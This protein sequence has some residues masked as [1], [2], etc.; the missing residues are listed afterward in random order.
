MNDRADPADS[1]R[2][3]SDV[4]A[5]PEK[6]LDR[7]F[8]IVF[9]SRRLKEK[10]IKDLKNPRPVLPVEE[11]SGNAIAKAIM[12]LL[13]R[14]FSMKEASDYTQILGDLAENAGYPPSSAEIY[15]SD[16]PSGRILKFTIHQDK[17]SDAGKERLLANQRG[18][19]LGGPDYLIDRAQRKKDNAARMVIGSDDVDG[20]GLSFLGSALKDKPVLAR[21]VLEN[22]LR[23]E[24]YIRIP[25]GQTPST[26][27]GQA[28]PD[29]GIALNNIYIKTQGRLTLPQTAPFDL[30]DFEGFTFK[31]ISLKEAKP[32][33]KQFASAQ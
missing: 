18:F 16:E 13:E 23:T 24:I 11:R 12:P 32:Q 1:R 4:A 15:N 29:G 2:D 20:W 25:A 19:K 33:E 30:N 21:Y 22:G 5:A 6:S 9:D 10:D 27:S 8:P 3:H 26:S 28:A 14:F 17:L 31:I 7:G